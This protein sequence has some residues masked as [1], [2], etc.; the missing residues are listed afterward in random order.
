M[1]LKL[2]AIAA[3]ML[4]WP[5]AGLSQTTPMLGVP[6]SRPDERP[7][8]VRE[9]QRPGP[10]VPPRR[11][12]ARRSG[13]TAFTLR[14]VVLEGSSLPPAALE[15]AWRPFIGQ[16]LDTA[17]LTRLTD[18]VAAVYEAH[19]IAIYTV[20]VPQQSLAEGVLHVRILEGYVEDVRV[21]GAE[22]PR[23]R[24][25]VDRYLAKIHAEKPLR[26]STLQRYVSL[27][28]D[29]PGLEAELALK[30]AGT[31][32]GV[33]LEVALKPHPVQFGL[34]VNSR[35][36]A[37]LG[38]TQVQGD[39]YLSSLLR[40]GDRTRLTVALPTDIERF[41]AFGVEHSQPIGADGLRL[42]ASANYLR[43]RPAGTPIRGHAT[44]GGLQLSYPLI[45]SYD[46]DAFVTI[47][48][49][50][51]D[52]DNA[53]LG[54]TFSNERTRALRLAASY[55]RQTERRLIYG[56]ATFSQGVDGLGA[57]TAPG[58]AEVDFRKLNARAGANFAIGDQAALR[59][60]G[61][62]QWAR[63]RLPG[64]EQFA[65]GGDEFGRAYPAAVIAG[66]YGYAGSAEAAWRPAALRETLQGAEIYGFVDG[67]KVYYRSRL[68][69]PSARASLRSAGFGA[70]A[71]VGDKA[72][73]QLEAA[74][75]LGND[76]PILDGR[77]WRGIV[78]VRTLF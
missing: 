53:F 75:G 6:Q 41:R 13:V 57:R 63:D 37:Y 31:D 27:I 5:T 65:L 4:A 25:L 56:S 24:A 54:F 9:R 73:V 39:L 36:T 21:S 66:D 59:L 52:T 67:G 1:R 62:A 15:P 46:H 74:R 34:A 70:R 32:E 14:S 44:S 72:F 28:R 2:S 7:P 47:G 8:T 30:N 11:A 42:T 45:R 18:A 16:T 55:S 17:G 23:H 50:G 76:L 22:S 51:A 68:G 12:Q 78:T 38:R 69:L 35:G 33:L 71:A 49:D 64:V 61:A 19:D 10:R 40:Q 48:L 3:I 43:T 77:G 29:I 26:R 20:A 58:I 60:A